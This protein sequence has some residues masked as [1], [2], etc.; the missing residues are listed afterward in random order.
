LP[1]APPVTA[2]RARA[3]E[4]KLTA[5]LLKSLYL[6]GHPINKSVF[7]KLAAQAEPGISSGDI[8][9]MTAASAELLR[10]L[11][12]NLWRQQRR[13]NFEQAAQLLAAPLRAA[14][15]TLL[16]PE[17]GAVAFSIALRFPSAAARSLLRV[18][19]LERHIYPACLWSL[20]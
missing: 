1:A 9:A 2:A 3:A 8:S 17:P 10:I 13:T 4:Q 15:V 20:S 7:L 12:T 19:L 6:A 16:Q 18:A 14:G 11:P 5:Q